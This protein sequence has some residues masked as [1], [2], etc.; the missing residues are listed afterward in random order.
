MLEQAADSMQQRFGEP[1][2]VSD[3]GQL[4]LEEFRGLFRLWR[5]RRGAALM[6]ARSAFDLN[7][8]RP[9][10]GNIVLLDVLAD[11][12]DLRFRLFGSN[13]ALRQGRDLTGRRISEVGTLL[14]RPIIDSYNSV[15]SSGVPMLH[16]YHDTA[17]DSR[18]MRVARLLLP[19]SDNGRTVDKIM[20]A[21]YA[22]PVAPDGMTGSFG[23]SPAVAG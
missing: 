21:S 5:A 15:L 11:P 7:D 22:R 12:P 20:V 19:L 6:P 4:P 8:L 10:M 3:D 9:W 13:V 16:W 1:C 17:Q 23:A 2:V 18:D 14:A